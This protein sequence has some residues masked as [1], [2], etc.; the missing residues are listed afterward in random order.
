METLFLPLAQF[1]ERLLQDFCE[2]VLHLLMKPSVPLQQPHS[3]L[4]LL[5]LRHHPLLLQ[6]GW[7]L[8]PIFKKDEGRACIFEQP[9]RGAAAV[10]TGSR[11]QDVLHYGHRAI[12]AGLVDAVALSVYSNRAQG[13]VALSQSHLVLSRGFCRLL[14]KPPERQESSCHLGYNHAGNTGWLLFVENKNCKG[15]RQA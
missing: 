12:G 3:P 7:Q 1:K 15:C 10:S 13:Q 4:R 9:K 6:D 2:L 14:R 5:D 8:L 11:S